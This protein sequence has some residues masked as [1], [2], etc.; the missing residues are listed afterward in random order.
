MSPLR[1]HAGALLCALAVL[2]CCC[3]TAGATPGNV[4]VTL[5]WSDCAGAPGFECAT[6]DLP[7]DYG[8]PAGRKLSI[9]VTRLPARDQAHKVG[10]LF[11]NYGGP[12]GDGVATTQAIGADLFG[13]LN[14]RFDIVGFDP[15]GVGQSEPSIDCHANQLREGVYSQPFATPENLDRDAFVAKVRGYINKCTNANAGILPYASTANV[16]RDMDVLRDAVGDARLNYLGFSYGTFL[17]ATYAALFPQQ[18]RSLVLDGALDADE[19]IN[20]PLDS[21]SEQSAGFERALSRFLAAC[22]LNQTACLG[23]GGD[24]PSGAFDE[25]VDNANVTPL[26]AR[27]GAVGGDD[28]LAAT[29]QA[30]YAKQLWP[31]L[32]QALAAAQAGNGTGIRIIDDFF[33]DKNPNGSFGPIADRYFT[34]TADEQNYPSD[35][36]TF[37]SAGAHSW[38]L[39]DHA[40]W[41]SGYSELPWGLYPVR[42]RDAFDGPFDVPDTS[43]TVLVVGT[44]YDPATPYRGA[45]R[46]VRELGGGRL[47]AMRGGRH[48]AY[49]GNSACIDTTVDAYLVE[50]EVPTAGTTCRQTV[51]FEQQA[52]TRSAQ[53]V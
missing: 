32:A 30:V 48:P 11:V 8:S 22:T 16:A 37:M 5:D 43:P 4:H 23:F 25:L 52:P 18:Y 21:L 12:G 53:A 3:A 9:A 51:P 40:W 14:E 38:G 41:N 24:D 46:L 34:L 45:K 10:S 19:Y 50:H 47:P 2:A 1:H 28:V 27:G 31:F 26:P 6:A 29:I 17:G 44:T 13:A 36:N 7:R 49:G 42:A 33:Y 39:F 20:R 35:V 15:R